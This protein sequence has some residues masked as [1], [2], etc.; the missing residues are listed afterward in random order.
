MRWVRLLTGERVANSIR[1]SIE[2][3]IKNAPTKDEALSLAMQAAERC[4]DALKLTTTQKAT[5]PEKTKIRAQ[6][7]FWLDEAE[8][9]KQIPV[10]MPAKKSPDLVGSFDKIDLRPVLSQRGDLKTRVSPAASSN[11][12][13]VDSNSPYI[14]DHTQTLTIQPPKPKSTARL[15]EP[16]SARVLPVA[17]KVLLLHASK[18]N[19]FKFPPWTGPPKP[20]E[21]DLNDGEEPFK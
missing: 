1:Q 10:W 9:I 6:C 3:R 21:F 19:G 16:V 4:M 20:E 8:R 14:Q 18:L 15:R 11:A 2:A 5:K 17:E 7:R 12:P 13:P